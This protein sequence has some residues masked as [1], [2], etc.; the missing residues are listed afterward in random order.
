[1]SSWPWRSAIDF[2]VLTSALYLLLRWSHEARAL[3]LALAIVGLRVLAFMAGQLN[4]PITS[5]LLE[6]ATI[7]AVLALVLIFQPELRRAL[8]RLDLAG[9]MRSAGS[10]SVTSA[11]SRAAW[12]M[13]AAHCGALIVLERHDAITELVSSGV[14]LNALVSEPLLTSIFQKDSPLHDGA[15]VIDGDT[16]THASAILPL[17][18]RTS[19]PE[20]FG[21][22][23][24][25]AMGLTDRSDAVTVVAS[26][27]RGTVTVMAAGE[28]RSV[29]TEQE[30]FNT[31]TALVSDERATRRPRVPRSATIGL[32]AASAGLAAAL[33]AAVLFFPGRS[34]RVQTVPLELTDIPAGLSVAEQSADSVQV[35]LRGSDFMFE[36][37]GLQDIVVRR[38]LAAAHNGLNQI[39]LAGTVVDVPFGL[40][41][42]RVAPKQVSV[43]MVAAAER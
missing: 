7:V 21:T 5:T 9:R 40:R 35:W 12:R 17:T 31:L 34:L 33:W 28:T 8:M 23:H 26:E 15:V 25:A 2:C 27:E 10:D 19:V 3:R 16:V 29:P 18:Q 14:V 37:A 42:E 39:S 43:R 38:S 30:L 41:V 1:M 36:T 11:V 32:L 22:R 24:R 13:A 6:G 20:E 4:L